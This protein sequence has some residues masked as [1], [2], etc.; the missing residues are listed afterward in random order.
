[1]FSPRVLP[2]HMYMKK[3]HQSP[4]IV[5]YDRGKKLTSVVL[6][7]RDGPAKAIYLLLAKQAGIEAKEPRTAD[8][9]PE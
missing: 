6:M 7:A 8:D 9:V 1:M 4:V 2:L 3:R 5:Y